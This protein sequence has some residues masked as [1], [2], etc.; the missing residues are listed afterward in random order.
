MTRVG[1]YTIEILDTG[2]FALD[3]GAMFGVVPKVMWQNKIAADEM[4]RIPLA[5]RAMLI[6]GGGKTILVDTGIGEKWSPKLLDLYHIEQTMH[7]LVTALAAKNI[8][9]EEVT[10]IITTHLHFDH[11]GGATMYDANRKLI[12][13]LPNATLHVQRTN[14]EHAID[15]NEKDRASYL[16]ENFLPIKEA[17]L[18]HLVDGETEILPGIFVTVSNGHTIG[19]QTVRVGEGNDAVWYCGDLIPTSAHLPIPWVMGYDLF[20]M[21]TI[22]EKKVLLPIAAKEGWRL[23]FEHDPHTSSCTIAWTDKGPQIA[24]RD[25]VE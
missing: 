1:S 16:P 9:P 17:G 13:T 6:R 18:L 22:D 21:Q 23:F 3:G 4:N 5:L 20:P 25:V 10:D 8:R 12:P 24:E 7:P 14:W 15:P 19:Q 2:T 11:V